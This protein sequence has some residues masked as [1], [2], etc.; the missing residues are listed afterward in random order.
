[1]TTSGKGGKLKGRSQR[2]V[3]EFDEAHERYKEEQY[4]KELAEREIWKDKER[5]QKDAAG[6]SKEGVEEEV[7]SEG[8]KVVEEE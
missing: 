1:M 6:T 5:K 3:Q 4:D 8:E 7:P 2:R